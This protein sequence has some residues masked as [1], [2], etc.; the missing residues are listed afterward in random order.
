[1]LGR[2]QTALSLKSIKFNPVPNNAFE[3][4]FHVRF[5]NPTYTNESPDGPAFRPDNLYKKL[6]ALSLE[7]EWIRLR[8]AE[9]RS[10]VNINKSVGDRTEPWRSLPSVI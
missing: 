9:E 3:N 2:K 8:V 4:Y 1:M 6:S 10:L 5:K 7:N